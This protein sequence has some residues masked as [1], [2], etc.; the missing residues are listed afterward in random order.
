MHQDQQRVAVEREPGRLRDQAPEERPAD[1]RKDDDGDHV[2]HGADGGPQETVER[3][4]DDRLDDPAGHD[5]GGPD[6]QEHEAPEDPGVHDPGPRVLE[7]LRLDER[8]PDQAGEPRRD[9]RERA[10]TGGAD[11]GEHPQVARH[12]EHEERGRAPEHREDERVRGDVGERLEHGRQPA[13]PWSK[14][15][16]S[17]SSAWSSTG[18]TA[19]NDSMAP[20]G[21]PGTLT[22]SV[23]PMTPTRPRDR[24]ASGVIARPRRP[25]GLGEAGDLVVDDPRGRLRCHVARRQAGPAGG[26]DQ[27]VAA[28]RRPRA[29]PRW[30]PCRPAR[31][32]GPPRTRDPTAV[33]RGPRPIH[34]RERRPRPR[35]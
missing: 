29:R 20:F 6:G 1:R 25:H 7:H 16:A 23:R 8:V 13:R 3:D 24:S 21:L 18:S 19:A 35:R 15:P 10:G 27:V 5:V 26:D 32:R 34:P 22:T 2:L 30:R 14:G 31:A 9:V 33:R 28:A 12:R 4:G 11:R 17:V